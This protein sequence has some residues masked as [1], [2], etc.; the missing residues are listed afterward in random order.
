MKAITGTGII[1]TS[2]ITVVMKTRGMPVTLT[3]FVIQIEA[4]LKMA[5]VESVTTNGIILR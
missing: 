2:A 1:Q 4:P 3:A 5:M